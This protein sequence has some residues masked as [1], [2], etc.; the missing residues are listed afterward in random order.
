MGRIKLDD[1]FAAQ[2]DVLKRIALDIEGESAG[3][4]NMAGHNS[5]TTGHNSTGIHTS[6]N[7]GVNSATVPPDDKKN[8]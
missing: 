6:H 5:V 3:T 2:S 4:R 1:L 8:S 7:S